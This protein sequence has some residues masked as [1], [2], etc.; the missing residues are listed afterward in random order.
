MVMPAPPRPFSFS[1]SAFLS[2][3]WELCPWWWFCKGT[4][5][6]EAFKDLSKGHILLG[7]EIHSENGFANR[8]QFRHF[9]SHNFTYIP[10]LVLKPESVV[11]VKVKFQQKQLKNMKFYIQ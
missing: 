7:G 5:V 3:A 9:N 4:Q 1:L 10:L 2:L 8:Q 6:R 11:I